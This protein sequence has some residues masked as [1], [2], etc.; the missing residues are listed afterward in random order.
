M[1]PGG[2]GNIATETYSSGGGSFGASTWY[3]DCAPGTANNTLGSSDEISMSGGGGASWSS[4]T[5][6]VVLN[7]SLPSSS[8]SNYY[9]VWHNN[10]AGITYTVPASITVN[11]VDVNGNPVSG[12]HASTLS[13]PSNLGASF[14]ASYQIGVIWPAGC[15]APT[16]ATPTISPSS[17]VC[18]RGT[19]ITL[20][21]SASGSTTPTAIGAESRWQRDQRRHSVH[22]HH[23][24]GTVWQRS[25]YL[26]R[27]F[28]VRQ[29]SDFQQSH[30]D[31]QPVCRR[32][33]HGF[34][35]RGLLRFGHDHHPYGFHRQ[36]TMAVLAPRRKYLDHH[37]RP[38]QRNLEHR[39]PDRFDRL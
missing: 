38:D 19:S 33:G 32:H 1:C 37:W 27:Q 24:V 20:T 2:S 8:I 22:L 36:H 9:T 21:E 31:R 6:D 39:Q 7:G 14:G 23:H 18:L 12:A 4:L 11:V 28:L 25:L 5:I 29:S 10:A 16:T 35:R 13:W 3:L 26:H 17:T 30:R 34:L 15:T